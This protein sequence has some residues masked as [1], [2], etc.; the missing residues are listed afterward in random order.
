MLQKSSGVVRLAFIPN[1]EVKEKYDINKLVLAAL[2]TMAPV[3]AE[4][5]IM[6]LLQQRP[7]EY[8]VDDLGFSV[9][10]L[11]DIFL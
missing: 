2:E 7:Q 8:S 9:I 11:K 6:K 3:E 4:D 1:A 5:Y 10:F